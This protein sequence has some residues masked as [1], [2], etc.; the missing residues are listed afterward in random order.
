MDDVERYFAAGGLDA[1]VLDGLCPRDGTDVAVLATLRAEARSEL[2]AAGQDV[3]IARAFDEVMRRAR[4]IR[5]DRRLSEAEVDRAQKLRTDIRIADALDHATR[6]GFA[7]YLAAGPAIL[8]HW[9]S[10]R[11]GEHPVAGAI[12]SG[13]IDARRAGYL[14]ITR[15]VLE[16]LYIWYLDA[17]VRFQA[18]L[19]SF[20]AA[21]E[22]AIQPVRGASACLIPIGKEIY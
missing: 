1:A 17:Q 21:L 7:E 4:I 20:D 2:N 22:W 14:T 10:A 19:P 16:Q 18:N 9:E 8:E 6:A 13:A 3:S 5:L 11:R 15:I 12:I